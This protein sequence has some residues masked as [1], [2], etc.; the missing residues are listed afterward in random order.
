M[1]PI[2]NNPGFPTGMLIRVKF[3]APCNDVCNCT[4]NGML[5]TQKCLERG[6]DNSGLFFLSPADGRATTDFSQGLWDLWDRSTPLCTAAPAHRFLI[7]SAAFTF[8]YRHR[9]QVI[10]C[11]LWERSR[12]LPLWDA[13]LRISWNNRVSLHYK[14]NIKHK[15]KS[16]IL[17]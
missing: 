1:S 12:V 3:M 8:C 17:T 10:L 5:V 13:L 2:V 7:R 14:H 11:T 4:G 9:T 16:E 15:T 6:G